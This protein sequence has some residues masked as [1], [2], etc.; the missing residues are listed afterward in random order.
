MDC[1]NYGFRGDVGFAE[2]LFR[3]ALAVEPTHALSL[4]RYAG[5]LYIYIYIAPTTILEF[6]NIL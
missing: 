6:C 2:G 3:R 1:I 5:P 4:T